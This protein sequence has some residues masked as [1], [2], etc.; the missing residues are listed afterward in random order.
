MAYRTW[1]LVW[2]PFYKPSCHSE[3]KS[4]WYVMGYCLTA[5]VLWQKKMT[6]MTSWQKFTFF[7]SYILKFETHK[8]DVVI[9]KYILKSFR[10]NSPNV[11]IF[12]H[13]FICGYLCYPFSLSLSLSLYYI[14]FSEPL[15]SKLQS[16]S[17]SFTSKQLSTTF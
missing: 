8:I 11:T 13:V 17:C 14:F 2:L 1:I 4:R 12:L 3:I 7:F 10:P 16:E 15:Q 9:V 6:C 5:Y